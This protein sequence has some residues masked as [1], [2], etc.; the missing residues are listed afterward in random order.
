MVVQRQAAP[1][2]RAQQQP[3][4]QPVSRNRDGSLQNPQAFLDAVLSNPASM[5]QFP[6]NL[7]DAI[8]TG[9]IEAVQGVFR[10][11]QRQQ[12]ADREEAQLVRPGEDPMDPAVQVSRCRITL[13][14]GNT[15]KQ[16]SKPQYQ[17]IVPTHTSL[18]CTPR[19]C[20]VAHQDPV[21]SL[22][23]T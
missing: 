2:P 17:H 9:D 12:E 16:S 13:R 1:Q 22:L 20:H 21:A 19:P 5:A 10:A 3:Q 11:L 23:L 8:S 6:P 18:S 15:G 14:T 7:R 4:Q